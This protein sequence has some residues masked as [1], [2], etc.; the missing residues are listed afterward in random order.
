MKKHW[1]LLILITLFFL[2]NSIAQEPDNYNNCE[3]YGICE[4]EEEVISDITTFLQLTDTPSAYAT[5]G[6]DCVKVNLAE[7]ALEFASC[8]TGNASGDI[9]SVQGDEWIT[10]GSNSGAV[11]LVFNT[12]LFDTEVLDA[13]IGFIVEF[14]GNF[15][16]NSSD[17]W[18]DLN[19]T[20]STQFDSTTNVLNIDENWLTSFGNNLWC[21][22]TGCNMTG[23]IDMGNNNITNTDNMNSTSYTLNGTTIQ[24]WEEV[25]SNISINFGANETNTSGPAIPFLLTDEGVLKIQAVDAVDDIWTQIV[26][27]IS[28]PSGDTL[29]FSGNI[30][31]SGNVT[32]SEGSKLWGNT[33][34]TFLSSPNGLNILEVCN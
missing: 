29:N 17:F 33:S 25:D 19:T 7:N 22:L 10:N 3:I 26:N 31:A 18:D 14:Q 8:A 9:T 28:N 16:V 11:N 1:A 6:G 2:N 5:F 27:V 21:A 12:S 4:E 24:D 30:I 13:I 20:N 23:N 15:N 34:C 32:V